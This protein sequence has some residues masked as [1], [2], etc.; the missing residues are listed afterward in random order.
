MDLQEAY[1]LYLAS[2]TIA[3]PFAAAPDLEYVIYPEEEDYDWRFVI[4]PI[5]SVGAD[6][7]LE[8]TDG[9][10]KEDEDQRFSNIRLGWTDTER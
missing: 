6:L 9:C 2:Q 1:D 3:D 7:S 4:L 8:P 5:D 10:E